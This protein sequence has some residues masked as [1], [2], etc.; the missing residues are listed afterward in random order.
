M[1]SLHPIFRISSLVADAIDIWSFKPNTAKLLFALIYLQDRA[2]ESW[3]LHEDGYVEMTEH[4][5]SVQQLRE[6]CF[7]SKTRSSRFLRTPVDDLK[8][9][10]EFFEKLEISENGRYL[11]W[12]FHKSF[13]R[14]MRDP[15]KYGLI[16]CKE[17]STCK[18]RFDGALLA[19]ISVHRKMNR[20]EFR[21]EVPFEL[22][23]GYVSPGILTYPLGKVKRKL[24]PSLQSWA[25]FFNMSFAVIFSQ[26]GSAPGY[27][28][29]TV[30][31]QHSNTKWPQMRFTQN[32]PSST[33]WLV[34][35]AT[36]GDMKI[37]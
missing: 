3:P 11:T 22:F 20:P 12:K 25:D 34:T 33:I 7:T 5:V 21:L 23:E 8:G 1:Q 13:F 10:F 27:T 18:R 4:F 2:P 19:K 17:I 15:E 32:S 14:K 26:E 24:Q 28:H 30:R 36:S 16:D 29:I 35:P 9:A 37:K 31:I 6:L